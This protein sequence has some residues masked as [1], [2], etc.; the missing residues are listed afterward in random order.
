MSWVWLFGGYAVI[1]PMYIWVRSLGAALA[2]FSA[3][4]PDQKVLSGDVRAVAAL[5]AAWTAIW[6]LSRVMLAFGSC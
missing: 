1:T 2:R 3:R 4:R 6:L 5:L